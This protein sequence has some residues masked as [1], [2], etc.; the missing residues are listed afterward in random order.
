MG[1]LVCL[2]LFAVAEPVASVFSLAALANRAFEIFGS[3]A[4]AGL[5]GDAYFRL[6]GGTLLSA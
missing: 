4:G 1:T 3:E 2:P 5:T 6:A